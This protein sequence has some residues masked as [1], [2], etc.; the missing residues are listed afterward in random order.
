MAE[1][2]D[3]KVTI[4]T[5]VIMINPTVTSPRR[6]KVGNKETGDPIFSAQF[7]FPG[8]HPDLPAFKAAI[9]RVAQAK[10]PNRDIAGEWKAGTFRVP[11]T[12]GDKRIE[13]LKKKLQAI[14]KEYDGRADYLAG[15]VV[16][17]AKSSQDRP[18]ALA[19]VLADGKTISPNLEGPASQANKGQF[20][21]GVY[22][23]A[24][25]NLSAYNGIGDNPDGVTA[26]TNLIV[27]TNKGK[28]L[29]TAGA[30]AAEVFKGYAGMPT[31][32]DPTA[33][34]LDDETP[35]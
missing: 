14:D 32:E 2:A 19:V 22:V 1:Y 34:T 8:D 25:L 13:K 17:S 4:N 35:F 16:V 30:P 20:Y 29:S 9:M 15:K 3:G 5:P 23:L 21:F 18:P 31:D 27:S 26:Y 7:V 6:V 24:Q 12:T 33:G 11:L 28:K 10:W